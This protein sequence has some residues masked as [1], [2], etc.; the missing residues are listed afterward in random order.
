[1]LKKFK[2]LVLLSLS[3]IFLV[4]GS[5][6]FAAQGSWFSNFQFDAN[7]LSGVGT[8]NLNTVV[9][10]FTFRVVRATGEWIG[11][12]NHTI[13]PHQSASNSYWGQPG[14][15]RQGQVIINSSYWHSPWFDS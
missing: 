3:S 8:S 11:Y 2:L 14:L 15:D 7:G 6:A 13:G 5:V 9:G 1:M 4:S 10:H 12:S